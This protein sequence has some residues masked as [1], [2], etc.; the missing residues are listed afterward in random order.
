MRR[1]PSAER[2]KNISLKN[3]GNTTQIQGYRRNTP[4][5]KTRKQKKQEQFSFLVRST[6]PIFFGNA[7]GGQMPL[8]PSEQVQGDHV[9]G[10][11]E[12]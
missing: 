9:Q 5:R 2:L 4:H 11:Q 6:D 12:E 7:P 8:V 3:I 10:N 1:I